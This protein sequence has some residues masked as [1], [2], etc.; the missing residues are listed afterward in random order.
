MPCL[1]FIVPFLL[2]MLTWPM[3]STSQEEP[4]EPRVGTDEYAVYAALIDQLLLHGK[5]GRLLLGDRTLSFE[6]DGEKGSAINVGGCSGMRTKEQT[7][8]QALDQVR[9]SLLRIHS[10]TLED[11]ERKN[12][13]GLPLENRFPLK[14]DYVLYGERH[15]EGPEK[16]WGT[17]DF[18]VYLSRVGFNQDQTEAL[19]YVA[20]VSWTNAQLSGG[21]Y[22]LLDNKQAKWKVREKRRVWQL[23]QQ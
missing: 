4:K 20:A 2:A 12:Q 10:S 15:P 23:G 3:S 9:R 6:C 13:K 18:A 8:R 22:V 21:D 14:V 5:T 11:F 19:V 7:P 17:P 16:D 1:R